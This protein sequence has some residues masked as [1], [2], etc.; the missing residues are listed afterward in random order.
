VHLLR[1]GS[2]LAAG[3]L[4]VAGARAAEPAG[5]QQPAA[6]AQKG[7]G[8][9]IEAIR[10]ATERS[11][12]GWQ[13]LAIGETGA[14]LAG[15]S[16]ALP[17][18]PISTSPATAGFLLGLPLYVLGGPFV[19]WTHGDF[20][21]GLVSFGANVAIPVTAG[22]LAEAPSCRG[23]SVDDN[24]RA[25]RFA[26]GVAIGMLIVPVLDALFLGWGEVPTEMVTGRDARPRAL[27]LR[28]SVEMRP[29]GGI[30][31]GIGALF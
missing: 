29:L 30:V 2:L 15:A 21:K 20:P 6:A 10:P 17:D 11:F 24:C 23:A 26:D 9:Q 16:L 22:F 31:W 28:P 25:V 18:R 13:I 3:A 19:H 27:S 8:E 1:R 4:W 12:Y 14:A 7:Q 5:T